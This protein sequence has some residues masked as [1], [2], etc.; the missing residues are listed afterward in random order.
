MALSASQ[1]RGFGRPDE[2]LDELGIDPLS[3]IVTRVGLAFESA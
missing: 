3:V 1:E 2:V